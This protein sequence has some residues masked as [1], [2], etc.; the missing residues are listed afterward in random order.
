MIY[1]IKSTRTGYRVAKFDENYD[2]LAIYNLHRDRQGHLTCDCPSQ[3]KPCKHQLNLL[4]AFLTKKAVDS[5]LVLDGER[6]F[7]RN[8][9]AKWI[10]YRP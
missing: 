5:L 10:D 7:V 9:M 1:S 3:K 8:P 6:G 4:P 2:V